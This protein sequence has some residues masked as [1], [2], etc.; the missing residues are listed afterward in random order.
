MAKNL[1]NRSPIEK[2]ILS[3]FHHSRNRPRKRRSFIFHDSSPGT[4]FTGQTGKPEAGFPVRTS[5]FPPRA[6]PPL[7]Y[8]CP[9]RAGRRDF[10]HEPEP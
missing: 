8:S 4:I 1:K 2:P 10:R 5:R 6:A 3:E 7:F 9:T